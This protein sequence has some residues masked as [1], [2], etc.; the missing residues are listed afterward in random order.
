[1]KKILPIVIIALTLI[2][3]SENISVKNNDIF[4]G[5]KDNFFWEGSNAQASINLGNNKMTIN[6]VTLTESMDLKFKVPTTIVDPNKPNTFI[7]IG[8]G[9]TNNY[10]NQK[11]SYLLRSSGNEYIYDTANPNADGEIIIRE[12]DGTRISGS[13]RFNAVNTDTASEAAPLVNMQKGV[14]YRVPV[15][16]AP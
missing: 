15:V 2:S 12:Y 11:A 9:G 5:V 14:F 13:F 4:Q 6:A 7:K 16:T 3:C 10:N 1:M 8:L